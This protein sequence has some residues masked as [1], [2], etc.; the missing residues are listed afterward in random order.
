MSKEMLCP[1]CGHKGKPKLYTKGN[2]FLEIVLWLLFLLPG[3][4]YSI[5]RLSSRYRGCPQ[6]EAPNMLPLNSPLAQKLIHDLE[7]PPQPAETDQPRDPEINLP[8]RDET[9]RFIIPE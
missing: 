8:P 7:P 9:G 6:C 3:L 4:I 1:N 2:I 5:W